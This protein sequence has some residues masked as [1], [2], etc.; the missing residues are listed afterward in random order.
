MEIQGINN[1]NSNVRRTVL[2]DLQGN[3]VGTITVTKA[4]K[5]SQKRLTYNY[6]KVSAQ[7]LRAKTA[8]SAGKAVT[9]AR[10]QVAQL[11][12]KLRTGE[13]DD[14]E[15]ENAL[16]HAERIA[17]AAKKK[18]N[19]LEEEERMKPEDGVCEASSEDVEEK[20]QDAFMDISDVKNSDEYRQLMKKLQETM[21]KLDDAM[22]ES[23]ETGLDEFSEDIDPGD[24]DPEDFAMLKK[25]HRL[26]E[27]REITEADLNYLK[28][29]FQSMESEKENR[30]SG[31]TLE[32][33][34]NDIPVE[35]VTAPVEAAGGDIDMQV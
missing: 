11:R 6:K 3:A 14:K 23:L 30:A 8:N 10:A 31:V 26:D 19:H 34:G 29:R 32:L 21:K 2:K 1:R 25:K 18:E 33:M 24:I 5:K 16:I 27:L 35:P 17:R 28:S 22:A 9:Q 4:A 13:Y 12:K 15:L 7:I 20:S